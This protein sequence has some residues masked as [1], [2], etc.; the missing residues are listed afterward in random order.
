MRYYELT[1]SDS[2]GQVYS[3]DTAGNFVFGTGPTFTSRNPDGTTNRAALHVEFDIPI[4]SQHTPQGNGWIRVWGVG[5]KMIGQAANLNGTLN[6]PT[7]L[8]SFTLLGGMSKGLPLAK[9]GQSG[10][11]AA[12]TIF[13]AFGNWEGI[14]QTLELTLLPGSGGNLSP[15]G[16]FYFT[17]QPGVPLEVALDVLAAQAFPDYDFSVAVA[18]GLMPPQGG[19]EHMWARSLVPFSEY[20]NTI[21]QPQGQAL[22]FD[23]YQGVQVSVVSNKIVVSDNTQTTHTT[24]LAFEDLI[25]QPTWIDAQQISFKTVLRADIAPFDQ[26][27]FPTGVAP[28]YALTTSEAAFPGA[29]AR[30]KTVFGGAFVV[31]EVHHFGSYREPSADAWVTAYTAVATQS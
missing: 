3:V 7:T 6:D 9:P 15:P 1:L 16:G 20:L 8:K 21:T 2:S 28:P 22:G 5:L 31:R 17:W 23:N 11:L 26:V 30:S 13:Q 29:P 27:I 14:N 12:G 18:P 10:I 19:V 24:Q 4:I 25:G